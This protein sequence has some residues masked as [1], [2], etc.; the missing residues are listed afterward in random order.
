MTKLIVNN[1]KI[2]MNTSL[3]GVKE[4]FQNKGCKVVLLKNINKIYILNNNELIGK[5]YE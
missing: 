5:N 1:Q 3:E 4:T 2:Q